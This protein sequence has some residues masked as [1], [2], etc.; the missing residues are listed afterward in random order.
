MQFIQQFEALSEICHEFIFP[1]NSFAMLQNVFWRA[2]RS[3]PIST[4]RSEPG[5][6]I[7]FGKIHRWW[8]WWQ[9]SA[10]YSM[11]VTST[12]WVRNI[13][14]WMKMQ[15]VILSPSRCN[16]STVMKFMRIIH[17]YVYHTIIIHNSI[18]FRWFKLLNLLL[19]DRSVTDRHCYQ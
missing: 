8:L 5:A 18:Y 16:V 19:L 13:A 10:M 11:Y 2:R 4:T 6:Q 15:N 14:A 9:P 12:F 3:L 17:E 1:L 7:A